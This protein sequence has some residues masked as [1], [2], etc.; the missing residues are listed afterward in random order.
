MKFLFFPIIFAENLIKIMKMN[1]TKKFAVVLFIC[2]SIF[3]GCSSD[4]ENKETEVVIQ[5]L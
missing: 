2:A 3:T 4:D 1:I 5:Q